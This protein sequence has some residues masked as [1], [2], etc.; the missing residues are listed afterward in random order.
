MNESRKQFG[1]AVERCW[2]ETSAADSRERDGA[3][4]AGCKRQFCWQ[5]GC[6]NHTGGMMSNNGENWETRAVRLHVM[7]VESA[8]CQRDGL[9]LGEFGGTPTRERVYRGFRASIDATG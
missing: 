6:G 9:L 1:D 3:L 8:P 2:A 5:F 7:N 4:S